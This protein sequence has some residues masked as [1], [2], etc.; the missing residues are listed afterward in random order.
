LFHTGE[1]LSNN[2]IEAIK[3]RILFFDVDN[4][5]RDYL[6]ALSEA[7]QDALVA[8]DGIAKHALWLRDN[9]EIGDK[10]RRFLVT[11]TNTVFHQSLMT[12]TGI[13]SDVCCW[14]VSYL[15]NPGKLHNDKDCLIR[16]FEG[17]LLV[18]ARALISYWKTY[19]T[20]INPPAASLISTTLADLSDG[21]RQLKDGRGKPMHYRKI[22]TDLLLSGN[23]NNQFVTEQE[24]M[25]ALQKGESV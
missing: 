2:D 23:E 9:H 16:V 25:S 4:P 14:L 22:R 17:D 18:H 10:D 21:R 8:G 24:I 3:G 19:P 5:S 15:Q 6:N 7:E 20:N 13:R 11:G 1:A 12:D